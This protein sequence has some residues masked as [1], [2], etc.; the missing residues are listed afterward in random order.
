[1]KTPRHAPITAFRE[2]QRRQGT[3]RVEVQVRSEDAA[4]VRSVVAALCDPLRAAEARRLL[5]ARFAAPPPA[6]IKALLA[7]APLDDIELQRSRDTG[8][9]IER[10]AS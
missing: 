7:S 9:P 10:C 5:K 2:R 6:G 3:I 8:R 1:M 4:L